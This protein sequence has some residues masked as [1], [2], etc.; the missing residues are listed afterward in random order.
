M[1]TWTVFKPFDETTWPIKNLRILARV[2]STVTALSI[3]LYAMRKGDEF[4]PLLYKDKRI[5]HKEIIS[6]R[7]APEKME[8]FE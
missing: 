2:R 8:R 6:W 1:V 4:R 5:P 3:C 7:Y